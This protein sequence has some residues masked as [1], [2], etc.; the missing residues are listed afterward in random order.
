MKRKRFFILVI[1][2]LTI[3][4]FGLEIG[5]VFG[6]S[7]SIKELQ[8][9]LSNSVDDTLSEVDFSSLQEI[10]DNFDENQ[11]KM[12][13]IKNIKSKV[14]DVMN[15]DAKISY[16]SILG[17]IV[18][19]VFEIIA[20]YLPMFALLVSVGVLSSILGNIK[21]KFNEKTIGEVVH[22][23]C[24]CV[25]ILVVSTLIKSLI[26]NASSSINSMQNQ[27]GAVFPLLLTFM[28]AIGSSAGATV[29]Q[30]ALAIF[31]TLSSKIFSGIIIPIF[32]ASFSF[33]IIG[34]LSNNVKL[35]KFNSFLSSLFKWLLGVLFTFFFAMLSIQGITAGTF[36]SISIRTVKFTM[37]SYV[38]I[39]GGYLSQGMDMVLAS[40]ILIK[41]S[42]GFVGILILITSIISPILEIVV[43]SLLLKMASAILQPLNNE[44][45]SNF[46]HS[47][48]KSIMMLSTCLIVVAFMYFIMIG[49][50]MGS[51]NVI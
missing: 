25:V 48:S 19:V 1:L 50:M 41:N 7:P 36:D 46:L 2:F 31:T 26:K 6:T 11:T 22:F 5:E 24:F 4:S 43:V 38:P 27:M 37:S 28:T 14:K 10:V 40:S 8:E 49:L 39:L 29:Y 9:Q 45:I 51:A 23:A 16:E 12:F 13:S 33:G 17:A 35:D 21:G 30:P 15:G 42:V 18:S 20:D 44:K 34:N 3:F 32:I 47:T